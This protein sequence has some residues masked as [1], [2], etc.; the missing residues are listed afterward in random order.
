MQ[1]VCNK[2]TKKKKGG[3]GGVSGNRRGRTYGN[4]ISE[5]RLDKSKDSAA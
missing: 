5:I 4:V 3:R 1:C 2:Q